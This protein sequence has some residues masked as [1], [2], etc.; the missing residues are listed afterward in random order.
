M[1]NET[2]FNLRFKSSTD[3]RTNVIIAY[4]DVKLIDLINEYILRV[5][6]PYKSYEEDLIF[7]Y[8]AGKN[9]QFDN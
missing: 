3:D 2:I 7:I 5:N 4:Y 9:Y 8:N 6:A 1:T